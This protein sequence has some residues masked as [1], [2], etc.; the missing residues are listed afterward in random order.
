MKLHKHPNVPDLLAYTVL[1]GGEGPP[2]GM[3]KQ[4][5]NKLRFQVDSDGKAFLEM[6]CNP[7]RS[8]HVEQDDASNLV[9]P[10]TDP[11]RFQAAQAIRD[12]TKSVSGID[13]DVG[14]YLTTSGFDKLP[15]DSALASPYGMPF[16]RARACKGVRLFAHICARHGHGRFLSDPPHLPLPLPLPLVPVCRRRLLEDGELLAGGAWRVGRRVQQLLQ[17]LDELLQVRR[18][19]HFQRRRVRRLPRRSDE[20]QVRRV[21][22]QGRIG[23]RQAVLRLP[24]QGWR[25]LPVLRQ[26]GLRQ[27]SGSYLVVVCCRMASER[28]RS[29]FLTSTA[30]EKDR[31]PRRG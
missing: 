14:L 12:F 7:S 6:Y 25:R 26:E 27:D 23:H 13:C 30:R 16:R 29:F 10:S 31:L 24:P 22:E 5:F 4:G 8:G 3:R 1:P 28:A 21:Q 17:G 20:G 18:Q 11:E 19:E 15:G 9:F 2:P